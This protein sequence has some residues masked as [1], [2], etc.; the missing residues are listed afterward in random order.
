M[1]KIGKCGH[2]K[3]VEIIVDGAK[4]MGELVQAE[5]SRRTNP[6]DVDVTL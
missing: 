6:P 2:A 3:A 4:R 1:M 5:T